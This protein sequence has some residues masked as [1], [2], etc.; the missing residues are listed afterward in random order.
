MDL[1]V[2]FLIFNVFN[3][4]PYNSVKYKDTLNTKT[5]LKY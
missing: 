4:L 2:L 3:K 5:Q 1:L